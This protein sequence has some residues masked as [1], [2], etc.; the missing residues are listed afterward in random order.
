MLHLVLGSTMEMVWSSL[1][2]FLM[3]D[4]VRTSKGQPNKMSYA[5]DRIMWIWRYRVMLLI[6]QGTLRA[7]PS[8]WSTLPLANCILSFIDGSYASVRGHPS[9]SLLPLS[10]PT[11]PLFICIPPPHLCTSSQGPHLKPTHRMSSTS[12]LPLRSHLSHIGQASDALGRSR[13][14][15][16]HPPPSRGI[17]FIGGL[18]LG[19]LVL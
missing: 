11:L 8:D 7:K 5:G 4:S 3:V 17:P 10:S 6:F 14:T 13:V 2:K 12:R 15:L 18:V 1:G 16:R 9:V 19:G